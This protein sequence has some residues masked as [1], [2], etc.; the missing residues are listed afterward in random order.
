MIVYISKD[1]I[2]TYKDS[3]FQTNE[4]YRKSTS[5]SVFTLNGGASSLENY[6]A[7]MYC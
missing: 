2:L 5:G 1:L 6:Q 3:N 4:D 7:S